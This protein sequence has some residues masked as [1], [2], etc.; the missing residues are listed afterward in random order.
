MRFIRPSAEIL[1]V[2]PNAERHIERCGRVSHGSEDKVTDVSYKEFNRRLIRL[3][4]LSVLEHASATFFIVCN[5]GISHEIVRHR[6]ASYTQESTRYIKYDDLQIIDFPPNPQF[7]ERLERVGRFLEENYKEGLTETTAQYAREILP[8]AT[9]TRLYMTANFRAW[10]EI[11]GKRVD[12]AAHPQI[13]EIFKQILNQLIQA[14]PSCFL[15]M[16]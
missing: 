6:M 8:L 14:A 12:K 3:G 10:R 16:A 4:H 11:I 2:T 7:R 15:D 1:T 5:R 13:Q 9:V